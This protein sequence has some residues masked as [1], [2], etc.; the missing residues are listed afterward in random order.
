QHSIAAFS[1]DPGSPV[2]TFWIAGLNAP[3][4]CQGA[5]CNLTL[6][7]VEPVLLPPGLAPIR[8]HVGYLNNLSGQPAPGVTPTPFNPDATTI[9][10][11]SG[12]VTSPHD[13]GVIRFENVSNAP[14]TIDHVTVVTEGNGPPEECPSNGFFAIW[15]NEL[16]QTLAV[17]QN[18]VLAE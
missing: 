7:K 13:T 8:V 12:D 1:T 3:R 10:I 15:D 17:G 5:D 6:V 4:E 11:S 9:L 18:L 14:V 16:P 2:A